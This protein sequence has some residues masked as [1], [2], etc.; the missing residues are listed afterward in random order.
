[1]ALINMAA[2]RTGLPRDARLLGLD[3]GSKT[4]GVALCDAGWSIASPAETIRRTKFAADLAAI[5][6]LFARQSV[7]GIVVGGHVVTMEV[8]DH[9]QLARQGAPAPLLHG[10][11]LSTA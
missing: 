6:A 9:P 3:P 10:R 5:T 4:I 7:R 11:T 2:L 8:F 1:M